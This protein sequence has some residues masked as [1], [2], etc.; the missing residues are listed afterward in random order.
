MARER[1]SG[2]R[3][4]GRRRALQLSAAAAVLA[5]CSSP[6]TNTSGGP[7]GGAR[8]TT[9]SGGQAQAGTPTQGGRISWRVAG[10]PVSFDPHATISY[11]NVEFLDMFHA[12]LMRYDYR[13]TPPYRNGDEDHVIGE[14]ADKWEAPDPATWV[15]H[16]KP[17]VKYHDK[18]PVNA[19]EV[20]A[21]DVKWSFQRALSPGFV[22]EEWAWNNYER[23]RPSIPR[24]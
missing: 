19:R 5:A 21:D 17:G 3:R 15:F 1:N 7:S 6:S 11:L 20:V 24:P 23:S 10:D 18:P 2:T 14:L 22:V 4:L 9:Q 8:S 12:K 16:L 13:T